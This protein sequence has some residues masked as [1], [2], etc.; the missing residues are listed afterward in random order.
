MLKG[1]PFHASF[2]ASYYLMPKLLFARRHPEAQAMPAMYAHLRALPPIA[3]LSTGNSDGTL[4]RARSQG[5]AW[6]GK[7]ERAVDGRRR[8]GG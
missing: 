3:L 4:D 1:R 8:M 2:E 5:T 7:A 6:N